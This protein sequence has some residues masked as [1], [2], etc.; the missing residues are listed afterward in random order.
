MLLYCKRARGWE[1]D[2]LHAK[3]GLANGEKASDACAARDSDDG[4]AR[5]LAQGD[6]LDLQHLT[7]AGATDECEC[8][9]ILCDTDAA[10]N[11]D[12]HSDSDVFAQVRSL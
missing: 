1:Y 2:C 10:S 6:T 8:V 3:R 4:D 11:V 7:T 12:H 5:M 9:M